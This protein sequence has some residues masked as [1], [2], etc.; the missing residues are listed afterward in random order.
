MTNSIIKTIRSFWK[1]LRYL[2]SFIKEL[3]GLHVFLV[4]IIKVLFE[5]GVKGVIFKTTYI[6]KH[7]GLT[8][9]IIIGTKE[10]HRWIAKYDC[11]NDETRQKISEIQLKFKT[12]PLI[13][14]IMPTYNSNPKWLAEAIES[15]RK[16]IYP[17]WE[18]CIADDASSDQRVIKILKDY[19]QSD[20]RIKVEFRN[21][22]GH[23]SAASNSA[24]QMATGDFIALLDHDDVLA[25]DALFQVVHTI[26][27]NPEVA[28][29]YSDEDKLDKK[30][31]RNDPYFKCDWNYYLFLGQNFINHLGVYKTEIV[32]KIGGFRMGFEG[33]QDYDLALRFIEQIET[34]QILHIPRVLYH[35][36]QHNESAA[37]K[38]DNKPYA[39]LAGQRA[40]VGHFGRTGIAAEVELQPTLYYRIHF[41][42]PPNPPPVNIIIPSK[43]N[44]KLL[45]GCVQSILSKT[46]YPNF[47]L[48][49][50]D[51]NSDDQQTLAYFDELQKTEG[52]T[53][54]KD[55]KPFNF[56]AI[57]NRA[58]GVA[59]SDFVL[60]LNDDTE[61]ITS[62][63]LTEMMSIALQ[64]G[65][66]VVGAKL[67]YPNQTIQH[68]GVVLGIGGVGGHV[69][70]RMSVKN[71]GYF[72]RAALL[73]EFSA[74]TGA[75]LLM[76]KDVF[77][78][79]G[80]LDE[81][82]L[83]VAFNDVDL[84]L[85]IREKGYR[86]VFTPFAQLYHHE[87]VSR[88]ND[89]DADKVERFNK[90]ND[91][92]KKKWGDKLKNDLAYNPN[93]TLKREDF[94]LACPPRF[95]C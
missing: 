1:R 8:S 33:S 76:R 78:E 51:N 5:D 55:E 60:L 14:V 28:L 49:V 39:A 75:C 63:W 70:K 71:H 9:S 16:Q 10:Y 64:P 36:R 20:P 92:M 30:G 52:V 38:S 85:K 90:E 7:S 23:I 67:L 4:K 3:G 81:V 41:K 95:K 50:V 29:I 12:R 89:L 17:H 93:L 6:I 46:D 45:E 43:N 83:A 73:Q 25:E 61:V 59:K 77:D 69:H 47:E 94:S 53:T 68:A 91:F 34:T 44:H 26:N 11:L 86:I 21:E 65:V 79:V 57:N 18:L 22:N 56:S 31:R 24:I 42:L 88:G 74:V 87:S 37:E 72:G 82:N 54:L 32:K 19:A 66:G 2:T 15:V 27:Q 35:W 58:V 13:S 80:G 48:L 84:C 40:L 62:D